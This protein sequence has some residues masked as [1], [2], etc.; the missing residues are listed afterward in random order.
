MV[1]LL[2][3]F[4]DTREQA[5]G[6]L[7]QYGTGYLRSVARNEEQ[8]AH[9]EEA[10]EEG[11]SRQNDTL[12]AYVNETWTRLEEDASLTDAL[13]VYYDDLGN[14]ARR[15]ADLFE[16]GHLIRDEVIPDSWEEA[17]GMIVPSYLHMMN[18]RLG[19]PIPEEA[20]L[21]HLIKKTLVSTEPN[22]SQA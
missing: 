19:I 21:A 12:A 5:V 6:L 1:V 9:L 18:N 15:F 17:T 10:F 3:A 22:P 16:D 20:Y 14:V 7:E 2:H 13:D 8:R 11:Y 4:F